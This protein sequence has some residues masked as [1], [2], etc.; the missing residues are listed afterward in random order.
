M[1]R[2]LVKIAILLA[3]IVVVLLRLTG[4]RRSGKDKT[5]CREYHYKRS[6][7]M[8]CCALKQVPPKFPSK[9]LLSDACKCSDQHMASVWKDKI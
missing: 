2:V 9:S 8:S 7:C 5:D 1:M 4:G 3:I 6:A